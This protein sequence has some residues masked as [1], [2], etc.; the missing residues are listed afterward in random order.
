MREELVA[1]E[2]LECVLGPV[3]PLA[4]AYVMGHVLVAAWEREVRL[5]SGALTNNAAAW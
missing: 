1:G 4:L 5:N 3:G 2:Q